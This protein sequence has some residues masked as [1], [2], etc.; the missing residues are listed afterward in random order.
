MTE[1]F[2]EHP[3]PPVETPIAPWTELPADPVQPTYEDAPR[4][5]IER[6]HHELR[7]TVLDE[8]Q[9]IPVTAVFIP[10]GLSG[11]RIEIGQ[12][13]LDASEARL[14]AISLNT[15][16]DAAEPGRRDR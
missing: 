10:D 1:K 15:L 3:R 9:T 11:A 12:W 7:H 5:L 6:H 2:W 8:W 13:S 14:L 16:A 4:L